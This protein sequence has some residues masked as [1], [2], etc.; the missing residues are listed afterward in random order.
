[1]KYGV[2]QGSVL[3]PLLFLIFINDLPNF[4]DNPTLILFADDTTSLQQYH[5]A[6]PIQ[7]IVMNLNQ[8]IQEWFLANNLSLNSTKTQNLNFSLRDGH[9]GLPTSSSVKFLGVHLDPGL[10]WVEHISQLA[11]KLSKITY[12]IR[13]LAS[14]VSRNT[15]MSAYHGYFCSSMS[16][17]VLNWGHSTHS[18]RI[19]KLQ[20][21]CVRVIMGL[22]YRDCCRHCF[23]EL[24]I[25]TFPS[26]FIYQCLT[27][28]IRN[29]NKYI[30]HREI[31]DYPT[32][33]NYNLVQPYHRLAR[34]RRGTDYYAVLFFNLL[35]VHI[36]KS[37]ARKYLY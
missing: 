33:N 6:E 27:Y 23:S 7:N 11:S 36:C 16:Y 29:K 8:N 37:L 30:K 19:F 26:T 5:P 20:R 24:Q 2:P 31:H 1:M 10:T 28:L 4:T 34:T 3:G 21:R 32:R 17:A 35:P 12:L 18:L 22:G 25:L 14:N 15:L 13:S 9:P